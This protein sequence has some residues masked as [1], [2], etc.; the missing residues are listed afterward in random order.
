[1]I[2]YMFTNFSKRGNSTKQP[3]LSAGVQYN[4][5][6]KEPTS[7]IN[8]VIELDQGNDMRFKNYSYAYIP[9]FFRYYRVTDITS[10]GHIW[11]YSLQTDVLATYRSQI[12]SASLYIL[13]SAAESN[14]R[15][16]DG[17][18]PGLSDYTIVSDSSVAYQTTPATA[19]PWKLYTDG[20]NPDAY[21]FF[22]LAVQSK[23]PNLG[24]LKYIALSRS[25]MAA[26][27]AKLADDIVNSTD[28]DFTQLSEA[29]TKQ[30]V[31]PIKYIKS[32]YFIP[33]EW[34]RLSGVSDSTN[35]ETGYTTITGVSYKDLTGYFTMG[36]LLAFSVPAHP[37]ASRGVYLNDAPFSRYELNAPPFGLIGLNN[38]FML[39]SAYIAVNYN[40]DMIT[41]AGIIKIYATDDPD[42][43]NVNLAAKMI[44]RATAQV[45]VPVS[46]TQAVTD[47]MGMVAGTAQALAGAF[48]LNPIE[49][50]GGLLNTLS[51]KQ[52]QL[53]SI[54]GTGGMAGLAGTWRLQSIFTRIANEDIADRGRPLCAIRQPSAIPG[55]ME[56]RNG[57]IAL[58]DATAGEFEEVKAYLE[59]GFYYE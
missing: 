7:V 23:T 19:T 22:V 2:I 42:I 3:A 43:N 25:N 54:G 37:Q 24:S 8:P 4:C 14:G 46:I 38:E 59:G 45:G 17:F 58:P 1:M 6:L 27:C 21:G 18:Y 26:L 56:V 57:D 13:R 11:I 36:G 34:S 29:F 49:M 16:M 5:R 10:D 40:V 12:G 20:V 50:G 51:S 33:L 30:I 35:I 44:T 31:D 32:A 53:S 48:T 9:D 47:F 15:V 28:F 41:G 52:P 55:Y 39:D